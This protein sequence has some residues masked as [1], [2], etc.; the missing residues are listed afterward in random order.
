MKKIHPFHPFTL[1]L[2]VFAFCQGCGED[3][4]GTANSNGTTNAPSS[5]KR[6][7]AFVTNT[8]N[9]FWATV[10]HG[11]QSAA[12]N[13]GDVDVDFRFFTN[14]TIEAQQE[15]LKG[16]V[17]SGVDGIAI[18]P[19]DAEKQTDFLNQ[20]AAKTL[21]VCVDSDAAN[22][23]RVCFIGSDNTAAGKQ[24]ADL[25]KAALPQGGKIILCVG[26]PNAENAKDR[27]QAI[28]N[29]LAGSNIQIIDTL[30]DAA[31]TDVA[32]KNAQEALEKH[33]DLAGL[34]GIYSYNGP[35]ILAAV[36]AAGKA[37][38]V[39]IVCFD[40]DSATLDGI[41]T[42]DIYGSVIQISTRIGY[43]TVK[44]MD[45]YLAGD[46]KQ[47]SDG[48]VLF[49]TLAVN[50]SLVESIRLYRQNMLQP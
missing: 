22:S 21:L 31:K 44:R 40:D 24:A 5:K 26:Y 48:K 10:R 30:A 38:K 4:K 19:I 27:I 42:E 16:L 37:G 41:A 20:V 35:A 34:V 18:S 43:E 47:L 11:C 8:T 3:N 49:N 28:Q 29:G 36:R 32:Q 6:R 45:K 17:A 46:K 13:L 12:Q 1:A 50:K 25:L 2:C 33:P 39:K 23:K 9:D 7:L 14:S 15:I